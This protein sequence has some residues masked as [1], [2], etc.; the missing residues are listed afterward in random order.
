MLAAIGS[1]ELTWWGEFLESE[2]EY[3]LEKLK[4]FG[5]RGL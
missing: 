3:E 4:T 5:I 1:A 2:D